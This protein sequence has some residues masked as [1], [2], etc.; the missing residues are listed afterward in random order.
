[1]KEP[2]PH[3]LTPE[4]CAADTPRAA[5]NAAKAAAYE[6]YLAANRA[7]VHLHEHGDPPSADPMWIADA[8]ALRD[9]AWKLYDALVRE[10]EW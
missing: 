7:I 5:L 6:A 2:H 9:R 3:Q 4:E 1:M 8:E 10:T